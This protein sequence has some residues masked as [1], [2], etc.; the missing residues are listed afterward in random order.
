MSKAMI[1]LE[2]VNEA[3]KKLYENIGFVEMDRDEDE[4]IMELLL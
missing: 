2:D 4:I 1:R 3:A